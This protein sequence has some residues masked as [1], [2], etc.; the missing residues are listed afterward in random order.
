MKRSVLV[1]ALLLLNVCFPQQKS[2]DKDKLARVLYKVEKVST[3]SSEE[4]KKV[5]PVGTTPEMIATIEN[6]KK[7]QTNVELELF[8]TNIASLYKA[9][10]KL[11]YKDDLSYKMAIGQVN[12]NGV[13][14]KNLTTKEKIYQTDSFG[15]PFNVIQNFDEYKWEITQ[16]TKVINGFNCFKANGL[17]E[18]YNKDKSVKR[19]SMP[20]VWFTPDIPA[21]FGPNGYDGLPGLV[22]EAKISARSKYYLYVSEIN[23]DYK[24]KVKIEKSKKGKDISEQAF[25]DLSDDKRKEIELENKK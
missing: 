7:N 1:L 25:S 5:Y 19:T 21:P 6:M 14:Y 2:V 15:E 17:K 16:E 18:Q 8:Y 23:Y 22:L 10:D 20:E 3:I 11:E 9:V 24:L 4:K 12:G 13:R